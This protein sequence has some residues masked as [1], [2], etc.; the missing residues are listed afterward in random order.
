[1]AKLKIKFK[2]K[3]LLKIN[4]KGLHKYLKIKILVL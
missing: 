3:K 1:M 4:L 2:S